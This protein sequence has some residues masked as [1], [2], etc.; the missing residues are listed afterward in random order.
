[1]FSNE[2]YLK[3]RKMKFLDKM[4]WKIDRLIIE[5]T[6]LDGYTKVMEQ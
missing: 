1:M 6:K 4:V 2:Q 5:K 3:W